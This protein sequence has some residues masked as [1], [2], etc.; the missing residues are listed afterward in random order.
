MGCGPAVTGQIRSAGVFPVSIIFSKRTPGS[1]MSDSMAPM[2][3]AAMAAAITQGLV[4][5][6]NNSHPR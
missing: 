1:I 4:R 5:A 3:R 6:H 2:I